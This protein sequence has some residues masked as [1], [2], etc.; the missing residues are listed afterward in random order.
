MSFAYSGDIV[1][2]NANLGFMSE[3]RFI[4]AYDGVLKTD[5]MRYLGNY[6]IR[7]RI[8]T[9]C[10]A[11]EHALKFDGDFVDCGAGFGYFV[12]S[13]YAFTNFE[14]INKKYYALDSFKG[15]SPA[16]HDKNTF[17]DYGDWYDKFF[18]Q[19]GTKKNLEIVRGYVPDT[20]TSINSEKIAFLSVDLNSVQPE[21]DC[22]QYLWDRIVPGGIVVLDDYG[23]PGCEHQRASH[24]AFAASK[25]HF[26]LSMPTGQGVLIKG[27]K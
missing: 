8:H 18:E 19:H 23:F 9:I 17:S 21:I 10:W 2:S 12:S 7:W 3:D 20:L 11:A 13:I 26:I 24:N 16:Y 4:A 22:L 14:K 25:S 1:S 15:L 27:A 5:F 6:D